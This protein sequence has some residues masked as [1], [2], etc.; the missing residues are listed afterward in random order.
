M[1]NFFS[2]D[3]VTNYR[4]LSYSFF[5][6]GNIISFYCPWTWPHKCFGQWNINTCNPHHLCRNFINTN[7]YFGFV[8][9]TSEV[10][11][12]PEWE[13]RWGRQTANILEQ[14]HQTNCPQRWMLYSCRLWAF[15]LSSF[16]SKSSL[17]AA[18][19]H[20]SCS[21]IKIY[22]LPK[23]VAQFLIHTVIFKN[24]MELGLVCIPNTSSQDPGKT[25]ES[26]T[27]KRP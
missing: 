20:F 3:I 15:W 11:H 21:T 4:V 9:G 26:W 8:S 18:K 2:L 14:L 17:T 7:V 1:E 10:C 13:D 12:V 22:A 23:A 27:L 5:P 16:C 25:Q 6:Q 24:T 19:Y